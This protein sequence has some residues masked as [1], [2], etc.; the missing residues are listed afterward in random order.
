[1]LKGKG[2]SVFPTGRFPVGTDQGSEQRHFNPGGPGSGKG[3]QTY[4]IGH[5]FGS[6]DNGD[7]QRAHNPQSVNSK[8]PQVHKST[9]FGDVSDNNNDPS[10]PF[11]P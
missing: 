5:R 6:A 3:A 1:M 10:R 9:R 4:P 7:K 8:G 2:I 11:N